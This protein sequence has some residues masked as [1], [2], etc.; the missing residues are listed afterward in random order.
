MESKPIFRRKSIKITVFRCYFISGI[1][2]FLFLQLF[3]V[4]I[5]ILSPII[6][7]VAAANVR[8]PVLPIA[9]AVNLPP[10]SQYFRESQKQMYRSS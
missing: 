10:E 7:P 2:V 3:F 6:Y 8:N 4:S 1:S 9:V 5:N